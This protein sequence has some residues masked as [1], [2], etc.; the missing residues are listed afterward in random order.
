MISRENIDSILTNKATAKQKITPNSTTNRAV[1][2]INMPEMQP[3]D[4]ED[5]S[6][7]KSQS[8]NELIVLT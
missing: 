7:L 1:L 3:L 4:M 5:F 6:Q 8:G 2:S